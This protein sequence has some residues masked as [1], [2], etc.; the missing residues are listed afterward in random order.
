[1][2]IFTGTTKAVAPDV[3]LAEK[4][5]E[6]IVEHFFGEKT[7]IMTAI[8]KA[9][10]GLNPDAKNYNCRYGSIS[11]SCKKSDREKAW[12]VDCGVAQTNFKGQICPE[13]S[14][15]PESNIRLAKQIYDEQGLN[16]WVVYSNGTYK[17]YLEEI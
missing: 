10:S 2:Y 13:E 5:V 12:S 9:E 15:N 11:K 3:K 1:M 4:P 14:M 16:A 17:K 6:Q 7:K 8:F